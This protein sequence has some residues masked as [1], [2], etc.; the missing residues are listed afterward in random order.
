MP[1]EGEAH[2]GQGGTGIA[3]PTIF[4][5]GD[6]YGSNERVREADGWIEREVPE[7]R[8]D[9]QGDDLR[10]EI[11]CPQAAGGSAAAAK[12]MSQKTG[13]AAS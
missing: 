5:R 4:G 11:D 1:C 8:D 7:Y 3:Q 9:Y 6:A 2:R 13:S 12:G 10:E